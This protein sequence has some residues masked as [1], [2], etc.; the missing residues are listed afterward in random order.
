MNKLDVLKKVNEATEYVLKSEPVSKKAKPAQTIAFSGIFCALALVIMFMTSLLG[1][2]TYAGPI[3][4]A[5]TLIPIR[6]EFGVKTGI[7]AWAAI[8]ILSMILL[9]DREMALFFVCF[10]WYPLAL[11]PVHRIK[12]KLLR[13]AVSLAIYLALVLLMYGVLCGVLGID[14]ELAENTRI[15]NIALLVTGA[16]TFLLCDAAYCRMLLLWQLKWRK[17]FRRLL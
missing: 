5:V 9:P 1:L 14:P 3:A 13:I 12:P 7:T 17:N 16:L 11:R 10:G 4:A 2:F 6:E 8:S 15:L